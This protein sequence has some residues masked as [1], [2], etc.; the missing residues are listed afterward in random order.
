MSTLQTALHR[1]GCPHLDLGVCTCKGA[2]PSSPKQ[3]GWEC[4]GCGRAFAPW[5]RGPCLHGADDAGSNSAAPGP[6]TC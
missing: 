4:P 3:R 6:F 2:T 1:G 5:F